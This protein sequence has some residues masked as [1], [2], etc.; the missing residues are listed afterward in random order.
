LGLVT[1]TGEFRFIRADNAQFIGTAAVSGNSVS[2]NLQGFS[3]IGVPYPDGSTHGT[4]TFTGTVSERKTLNVTISFKTDAGT[5]TSTN[6]PMVFNALYNQASS[7]ATISGNYTDPATGT[8]FS[9]ASDGAVFAQD[10]ASGCVV[11]GTISIINASYN[12]YN[13]SYTYANCIGQY[14]ILNG[15]TATGL[16]ALDT[17]ASPVQAIIGVSGTVGTQT[18]SL[19]EILNKM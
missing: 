3:E 13:I 18:V 2:G 15:V 17:S 8:V 9:V 1:E 19:V 5:S 10:S 11:N 6:V 7:L 14:T 4:G 16:G 12:A